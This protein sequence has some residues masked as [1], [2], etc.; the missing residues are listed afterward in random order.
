MADA[1]LRSL[2]TLNKLLL[3]LQKGIGNE[4]TPLSIQQC[5]D[6]GEGTKSNYVKALIIHQ[7]SK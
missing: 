5:L 1:I 7:I 3:A 2:K 4:M 6:D